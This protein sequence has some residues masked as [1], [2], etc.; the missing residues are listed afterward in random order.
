MPY[1]GVDIGGT[2]LVA[3]LVDENFRIL[4]KETCKLNKNDIG[5]SLV[6]DILNISYA[7][8]EKAGCAKADVSYIG[9]GTP[10]VMDRER[11]IIEY[12]CNIPYNAM[13]I[14]DLINERWDIPVYIENDASCAAIG[15]KA[16]GAARGYDNALVITI[17]TGIGGGIILDNKL[18]RG[19]EGNGSETGHTV[20]EVNG[21]AC[22]CGRFGCW[23]AYCSATGLKRM[24]AESMKENT[25][26]IMWEL[27]NGS[28]SGVSG[29]TAFTAA[30]SGDVAAIAVVKNYLKYMAVGIG[31][32]VNIFRPDIVCLG[33]GVSNE[34]DSLLLFPLR[35]LVGIECYDPHRRPPE[36]VKA[37]LGNDAGIVGAATLGKMSL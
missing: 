18:F 27:S 3:G 24:T 25:D 13:P 30:K 9:I 6:N 15:E 26:S 37:Q 16:A 19:G 22:A 28:L 21:A 10:G 11:G 17:G 20:L 31:N 7:C 33:G 14:R 2:N 23:E 5:S 29:R 36:V 4:S 12:S 8:L 34:E 32:M 1:L 35:E